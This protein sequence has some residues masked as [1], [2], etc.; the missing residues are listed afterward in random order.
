MATIIRNVAE[1]DGDVEG[2]DWM[3]QRR[4]RNLVEKDGDGAGKDG[5]WVREGHE[6]WQ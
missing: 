6:M 4:I 2:K 3:W 1:K 5:E